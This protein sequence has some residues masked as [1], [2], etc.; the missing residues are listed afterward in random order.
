MLNQEDFD[1]SSRLLDNKKDFYYYKGTMTEPP[2]IDFV[3]WFILKDV[4]KLE[5]HNEYQ[6]DKS[7]NH[8]LAFDYFR[9]TQPLYGRRVYRTWT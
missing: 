6:H 9:V 5:N 4:L 1:F 8:P 2:A 7:N 3:H